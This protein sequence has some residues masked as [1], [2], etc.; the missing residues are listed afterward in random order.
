MT[1][2]TAHALASALDTVCEHFQEAAE[3]VSALTDD[4]MTDAEMSHAL[5]AHALWSLAVIA[6]KQT[7][8]LRSDLLALIPSLVSKVQSR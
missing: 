1:P 6:R 8:A 5:D 4:L 3:I 7:D 2:E